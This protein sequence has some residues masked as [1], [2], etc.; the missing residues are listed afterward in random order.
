MARKHSPAR[1]LLDTSAVVH[2]L[3]GHTLQRAAVREAVAGGQVLVPVFVRMEYLRGVVVNLID[4]R[5]RGRGTRRPAAWASSSSARSTT[6][7]RRS[8]R[9]PTTRSRVNSA[10]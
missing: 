8:R 3:H 9:R 5:T 10:G 1:L 4:R 7:T 2:L 6:S